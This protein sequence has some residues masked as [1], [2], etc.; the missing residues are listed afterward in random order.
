M[1]AARECNI[2]DRQYDRDVED[3]QSLGHVTDVITADDDGSDSN[4]GQSTDHFTDLVTVDDDDDN[5]D[6][7]ENK[8][9]YL[10][11]PNDERESY[12][13]HPVTERQLA[14][15]SNPI[16]LLAKY[17]QDMKNFAGRTRKSG[18]R[19]WLLQ[20]D[21]PSI[22]RMGRSGGTLKTSRVTRFI[23]L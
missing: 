16:K 8:W 17:A 1:A 21:V 22:L 18:L 4:T 5:F 11:D 6:P 9:D 23:L 2:S 3:A 20:R 15:P 7:D 10:F 12:D 19:K 14:I 13:H